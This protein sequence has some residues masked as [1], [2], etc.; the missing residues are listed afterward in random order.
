[1]RKLSVVV[2]VYNEAAT[3]E[4]IVR[5]VLAVTLAEGDKEL[6]IVDDGS[7]DGSRSIVEKLGQEYP[8]VIQCVY[9]SRNCGKGAAVRRGLDIASGDIIIV[10]DADL[11]YDPQDLHH[12]VDAYRDDSVQVVFGAR[13]RTPSRMG[14]LRYYYGRR[15]IT[16]LTNLLYGSHLTDQPT[17]YKSARATA[18]SALDLRCNGFEFCA[19]VTAKLLR[20]GYKIIEVP[21]SYRPR[22]IQEGKKL[23]ARHGLRIAWTLVR[24]R[25]GGQ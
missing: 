10:Q 16:A 14:Y 22:S 21:I 20:A 2:P 24:L 23:R 5:R 12:I 19:E 1:M 8:D 7:S 18:L 25:F 4:Q 6:I 9:C 11:E 15:L 17:G 3:L 13:A